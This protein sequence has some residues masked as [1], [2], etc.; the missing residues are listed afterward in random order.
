MLFKRKSS[1]FSGWLIASFFLLAGLGVNNVYAEAVAPPL[2]SIQLGLHIETVYDFLVSPSDTQVRQ[3]VWLSHNFQ[4]S[5]SLQMSNVSLPSEKIQIVFTYADPSFSGMA[6]PDAPVGGDKI[7]SVAYVPLP[8][9]A[10]CF[11][12]GVMTLLGMSKRRSSSRR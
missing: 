5:D 12:I 3:G 8:T 7:S 11:L 6:S 2:S 10:W 9:T 4:M 1:L